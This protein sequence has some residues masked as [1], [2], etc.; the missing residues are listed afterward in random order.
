ME[1]EVEAE[2][3]DVEIF[4]GG[5]EDGQD[6][7]QAHQRKNTGWNVLEAVREYKKRTFLKTVLYQ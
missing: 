3:E 2:V 6:Q 4:F 1:V 7:E 5:N